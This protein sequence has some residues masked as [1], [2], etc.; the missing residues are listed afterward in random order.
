MHTNQRGKIN[1]EGNTKISNAPNTLF[2]TI[3]DQESGQYAD[4]NPDREVVTL[5]DKAGNIN[6]TKNVIEELKDAPVLGD[7]KINSMQLIKGDLVVRVS[8]VT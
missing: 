3:I 6:W 8:A 7:K 1:I 5:K 4:V 2:K